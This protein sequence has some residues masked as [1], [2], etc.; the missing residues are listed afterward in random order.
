MLVSRYC[1]SLLPVRAY[2]LHCDFEYRQ[3]SMGIFKINCCAGRLTGLA[4]MA[5][6]QHQADSMLAV[7]S[8]S[9]VTVSTAG[10]VMQ[11]AC[12]SEQQ[13]QLL[14]GLQHVMCRDPAVAPL[15][16][17][18]LG[19][20][21]LAQDQTPCR[22]RLHQA[23]G[24]L[25]QSAEVNICVVLQKGYQDIWWIHTNRCCALHSLRNFACINSLYSASP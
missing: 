9:W 5:C 1:L 25:I 4:S 12:L 22:R 18:D 16:G 2:E 19:Q 8:H 14:A 15:S 24:E 10:H 21:R 7:S 6:P 20:Y 17:C 3:S 23:E 11:L 13:H